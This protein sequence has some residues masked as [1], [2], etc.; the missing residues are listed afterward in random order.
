MGPSLALG[1]AAG[2]AAAL[3]TRDGGPVGEVDI[4]ELQ[5]T[6]V[7]VVRS[8]HDVCE[9]PA[10]NLVT[11]LLQHAAVDPDAVALVEGEKTVSF[12]ELESLT[13][14][15]A[16]SIAGLGVDSG[17]RVAIVCH[18]DIGFVT[19]YLG[20]LWA[21]AVAVPLNPLTPPSVLAARAERVGVRVLLCGAGTDG[22]TD[23]PG[24]GRGERARGSRADDRRGRAG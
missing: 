9:T 18:N 22:L 23:L 12:A 19:S 21:G 13:A 7:G 15:T 11:L 20:A 14:R 24:C 1:Q 10:V 8:W 6:L 17:D 5:A 16:A 3:A 2:T 4:E